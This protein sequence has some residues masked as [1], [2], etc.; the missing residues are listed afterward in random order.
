MGALPFGRNSP[1]TKDD[2]ITEGRWPSVRGVREESMG[3][4][5]GVARGLGC[6]PGSPF[7]CLVPLSP[8]SAWPTRCKTTPSSWLLS[9]AT[10]HRS[11]GARLRTVLGRRF[12]S[13]TGGLGGLTREKGKFLPPFFVAKSMAYKGDCHR[14]LSSPPRSHE[15]PA[16]DLW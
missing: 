5:E 16:K 9:Y 1:A 15:T 10:F 12:V 3:V 7:S 13:A 11:L 14:L 6:A 8:P 2:G 4:F